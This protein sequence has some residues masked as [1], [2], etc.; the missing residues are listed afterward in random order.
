M[1][2]LGLGTERSNLLAWAM[3]DG[4]CA[5]WRFECMHGSMGN[6]LYGNHYVYASPLLHSAGVLGF[7]RYETAGSG[8]LN[9]LSIC[10]EH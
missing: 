9:E 3:F 8:N 1:A 5:T 7:C 2:F 4:E 6:A 10:A